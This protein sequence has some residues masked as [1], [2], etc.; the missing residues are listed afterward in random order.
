MNLQYVYI[1]KRDVIRLFSS[2]LLAIIPYYTPLSNLGFMLMW[3]TSDNE[4]FKIIFYCFHIVFNSSSLFMS[5]SNLI[6]ININIMNVKIHTLIFLFISMLVGREKR[7]IRIGGSYYEK[8]ETIKFRNE[9]V[10]FGIVPIIVQR[11]PYK[12]FYKVNYPKMTT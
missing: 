2:L 8:N 3:T 4:L 12:G 9:V 5:M 7:M 6:W 11:W 10:I 1:G